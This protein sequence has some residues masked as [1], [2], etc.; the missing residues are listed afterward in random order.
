MLDGNAR[1][2][3]GTVASLDGRGAVVVAFIGALVVGTGAAMSLGC[4][5]P[6]GGSGSGGAVGTDGAAGSGGRTSAPG[7]TTSS[8]TGG[9]TFNTGGVVGRGGMGGGLSAMGGMFGAGGTSHGGGMGVLGGASGDHGISGSGGYTNGGANGGGAGGTA[10]ASS[11]PVDA[12]ADATTTDAPA[13]DDGGR[14]VGCPGMFCEDFE[15]GSIDPGVWNVKTSGGQTVV[16]QK[17]TV[18]HG[19]YAAQFHAAPSVVSY[20][21]IIT[22]NAPAGL[23]GHHFGRAYFN[24][25]P[26]PPAAHTVFLFAGSAGFPKFKYLEVAGAGTTWQL[27]SVNLNGVDANSASLPGTT[28]AYSGGGSLPL[29][30]WVCL[31]WEFNDAPDQIRVF[32]NGTEDVAFTNIMLGGLTT[33]QVGGFSDFGFGYYAWHPASYPFDIYYDDIVLDTKRI[34]C[35]P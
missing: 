35:L 25:T 27:T 16:V 1:T 34:G 19:Q 24:V 14:P 15:S 11:F 32:V 31:E 18:A 6:R 28:E 20:D 29:A 2:C 13:L 33:G 26:K 9:T 23:R 5:T 8:G 30:K 17:T 12:S 4:S 10:G 3:A 7:G 21:L 22:K